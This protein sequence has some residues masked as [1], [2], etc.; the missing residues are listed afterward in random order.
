MPVDCISYQKSG[1]FSEIINDYLDQN[2]AIKDLYNQYPKIEN[3]KIQIDQKQTEFATQQREVLVE[4]LTRQNQSLNLYQQTA[5]NIQ[6]LKDSNTFTIT[7]GHQLSLF[8]GSLYFLYKIVSVIN[9]AKQLSQTYPTSTFVPVFWMA[10]EDHDFE[11]I[12]TFQFKEKKI[13]WQQSQQ[14]AVGKIATST[15]QPVFDELSNVLGQGENAV[16]LKELFKKTY[17][18]HDTLAEAT[19]FLVNELFGD[20][21]LVIID[22]DDISLK[23]QLIPALKNEL[24]KNTAFTNIQNTLQDFPYPAQVN[25][26]EINLFYLSENLRE[27]IVFENGKFTVLNTDLQFSEAEMMTLVQQSPERFSPNVVVRPLYQETILPNLAYIGGGGEIAYWLQLKKYFEASNVTFPI[28]VVRDS[29]L[30]ISNKQLQKMKKLDITISDLFMKQAALIHHKTV[31]FS[32]F[33]L[34]LE[35]LKQQLQDQFASLKKLTTQTDPSFSG[36][37]LAQEQKQIKG[38][39]HLEKRLLKAQKQKHADQLNRIK[40][41]QDTLFPN[42]GL[43]ERQLNFSEFYLEYGNQFIDQ[44]VRQLNPL[45]TDFKIIT[46]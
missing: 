46:I 20:T 29:V 39:L 25:P 10:T 9:L 13:K 14:G 35:A 18:Q 12:S 4:A 27:R 19:R 44:L 6:Q 26:R 42:Q 45:C 8:T 5:S 34:S 37:V 11:E 38:L 36:A 43:Q 24:F 3:F 31:L 2:P 23:K 7:T 30:V 17:L 22:G 1:Y 32:E 28:L 16:Y 21:G 33:P 41:L 40:I 15:L